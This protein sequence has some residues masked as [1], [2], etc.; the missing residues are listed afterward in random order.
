M[1]GYDSRFIQLA[2]EINRSM[3]AR[4][5]EM[6][7]EALN[8]RRKPLNGSKVLALGVAY[9]RGVGDTRESPA[10]EVIGKL[11]ERG[12]EVAY[13]DP[14][15]P[16]VSVDGQS[17]KAVELTEQEITSSDCVLILDRS[18]RVRVWTHPESGGAGGRYAER[19]PGLVVTD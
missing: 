7:V 14:Y 11:R 17:M 8:A 12:A 13:A 9:K 19:N 4:T 1:T 16:A 2:D 15:V 6:V 18:C 10:I 3:P 5:V